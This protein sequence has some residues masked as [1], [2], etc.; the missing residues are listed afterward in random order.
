MLLSWTHAAKGES[1]LPTLG[2]ILCAYAIYALYRAW[3]QRYRR[4]IQPYRQWQR[5][6]RITLVGGTGVGVGIIIL[7]CI[8]GLPGQYENLRSASIISASWGHDFWNPG[9]VM[10][11]QEILPLKTQG[12]P[13]QP[14][15]AYLHP[16]TPP[17]QLLADKDAASSEPGKQHRLRKPAPLGKAPKT[18][19]HTT[20]KKDKPSAKPQ[21]KNLKNKKKKPQLPPRNLASNPQ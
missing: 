2:F 9:Q 5:K 17:A 13:G 3:T 7:I 6:R 16:E 8:L 14:V 20:V 18:V 11:R 10:P 21:A 12:N 4:R 19:V 1:V 15:Y